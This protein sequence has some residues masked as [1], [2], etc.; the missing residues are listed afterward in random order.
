M[1]L[2]FIDIDGF[3]TDADAIEALNY[4]TAM[5]NAGVNIRLTSNSW[6]RRRLH[7]GLYDAIN[8]SVARP[9]CFSSR[10]QAIHEAT[11]INLELSLKL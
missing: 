10:Q 2:K 3:G 9:A 6:G 8:A 4:A 1:A 7:Q 11:T 5:R